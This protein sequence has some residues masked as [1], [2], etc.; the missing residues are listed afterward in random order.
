MSKDPAF[1]F[2]SSDFLN[3]I[4]DLTME[5]RGQYI[6]LLCLQ[7]QKTVL[8]EKTIRLS[9]GN[10][11]VDVIKKFTKDIDGNYFNKRLR[12]EMDKREFFTESRRKNGILGGRPRKYSKPSG[13]PSAEPLASAS[14][15]LTVNVNE[16]INDNKN[17]LS[18]N[19]D[20]NKKTIPKKE[21]FL[22]YVEER[23][24]AIGVKF[25]EYKENASTKYD[26]WVVNGWKDLKGNKITAWKGKVVSN[27]QY[28]KLEKNKQQAS[29]TIELNKDFNYTNLQ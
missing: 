25:S 2:Y 1:L 5:E 9:V 20:V 16:D 8:S 28:W 11:S 21:E 29:G 24:A 23:C 7:H 22:A 10:V 26:A 6:T 4:T 3:G 13:L 15:N 14:E 27:L 19:N 18:I 12:V 17:N